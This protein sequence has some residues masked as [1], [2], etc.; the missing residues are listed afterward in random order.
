MLRTLA[1]GGVGATQLEVAAER[2]AQLAANPA[3]AEHTET[4]A[5]AVT[6]PVR[7]LASFFMLIDHLFTIEVYAC[8]EC[9]SC[10]CY[11]SL[12]NLR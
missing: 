7:Y 3:P 1:R 8:C 11:V 6:S 12:T 5:T 9:V 10:M 4:V 2:S